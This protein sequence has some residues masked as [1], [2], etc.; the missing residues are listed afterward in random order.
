[1]GKISRITS[2]TGFFGLDAEIAGEQKAKLPHQ[3][4][5]HRIVS[6][7]VNIGLQNLT[8]VV[9]MMHTE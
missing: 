9:E 6:S 7:L 3:R 8:S 1:M 4:H 2:Q 5:R